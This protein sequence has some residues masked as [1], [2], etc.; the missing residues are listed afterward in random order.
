ME[1]A[2]ENR[3]CSIIRKFQLHLRHNLIFILTLSAV[4]FGLTL[5]FLLRLVEPSSDALLGWVSALTVVKYFFFMNQRL[6]Q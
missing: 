5:G 6:K 4:I 2:I 3:E 1:S